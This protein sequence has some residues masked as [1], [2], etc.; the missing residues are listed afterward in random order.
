MNGI[1]FP[2][3][4]SPDDDYI[5]FSESSFEN[6]GMQTLRRLAVSGRHEMFLNNE[7][8]RAGF[9]VPS[10]IFWKSFYM[11]RHV[12]SGHLRYLVEVLR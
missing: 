11:Y 8:Q 12:I 2:F 9:L 10:H 5:V 1:Q 7:V 4:K 6:A 3:S